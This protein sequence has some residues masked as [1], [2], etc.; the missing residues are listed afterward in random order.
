MKRRYALISLAIWLAACG[1]PGDV[2]VED[3]KLHPFVGCWQS[4]DGLSIEDWTQDPSGWLFGY[5]LSRDADENIKFF[6]QM[7]FDGEVLTVIGPNDDPTPFKLVRSGPDYVFENS[8]HDYP[9]RIT[10]LPTENRLDANISRLDGSDRIDF[11]K[12]PCMSSLK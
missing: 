8:D 11:P 10:Y 4:E 6:E 12:I 5:A 1:S 2:P 3:I 9:Q 7:R